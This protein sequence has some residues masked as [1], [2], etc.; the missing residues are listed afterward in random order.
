MTQSFLKHTVDA[1]LHAR[2]REYLFHEFSFCLELLDVDSN[3]GK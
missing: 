2:N 3:A 1:I